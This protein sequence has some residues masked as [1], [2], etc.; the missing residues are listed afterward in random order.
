MITMFRRAWTVAFDATDK[1][2]NV[3]ILVALVPGYALY[4][5]SHAFQLSYQ[6][7]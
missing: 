5:V 2:T 1:H 6:P 7:I 4:G 3:C